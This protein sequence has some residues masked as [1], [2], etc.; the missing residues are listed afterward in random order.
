[1]F[2]KGISHYDEVLDFGVQLKIINKMGAWYDY[3]GEKIGQ[4]RANAV[5]WLESHL[6]IAADIE[7]QIRETLLSGEN[8]LVSMHAL[9]D[10]EP[11]E[12]ENPEAVEISEHE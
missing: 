3:G 1:M 8:D 5:I 6:D 7:K 4:G 12:P 11:E 9:P 2:G 10:E